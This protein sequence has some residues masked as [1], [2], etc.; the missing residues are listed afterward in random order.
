MNIK[1]NS[2]PRTLRAV[3]MLSLQNALLGEIDENLR[4]VS[5]EWSEEEKRINIYFY[6][7]GE[8]SEENCS[9]AN[10]IGGMV[11]GDFDEDTEVVENCIRLDAPEDIPQ[12][13][14]I[15]YLRKEL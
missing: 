2:G 11:S 8:I 3:I 13:M 6:Y 9:S 4:Q 15:A 12:H 5:V 7:Q 14:D 10:C 1:F